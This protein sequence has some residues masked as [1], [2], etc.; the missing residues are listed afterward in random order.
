MSEKDTALQSLED[1]YRNLR[2][3]L[4]GLDVV[5]LERGFLDGWSAKDIVAHILGWARESTMM[6]ERMARGE[7]PAP[8]GTDYSDP[9]AWNAR[10][11]LQMKPIS[12]QTVVAAWQ[13]S[14]MNFVR[15]ARALPDDRFAA[16]EDGKPSTATRILEGNG[17]VHYKEHAGHIGEWRKREG[18]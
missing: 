18:I 11:A 8:E 15:A 14:H 3:A 7:R 17:Y 4:D 1:E 5:Q 10:F 13:Q 9:D 2:Q 16:K 12:P 6:L